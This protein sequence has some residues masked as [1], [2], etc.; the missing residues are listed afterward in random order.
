MPGPALHDEHPRQWRADDLVLLALDRRDDVAELSRA[1]FLECGDEGTLA[2]DGARLELVACLPEELVVDAAQHPTGRGEV[3]PPDQA[4]RFAA[5]GAVE[6]LGHGGAPVDDD[7]LRRRVGHGDASDVEAVAFQASR[8][9]R[10]GFVGSE[11]IDP[12][13]AE[14]LVADLGLGEPL[15][16]LLDHDVAFVPGLEGAAGTGLHLGA[17]GAGLFAS[18]FEAGVGVVDVRLLCFQFGIR[19]HGDTSAVLRF[20]RAPVPADTR[21]FTIVPVATGDGDVARR[22]RGR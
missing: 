7:R 12:A 18:A 1:G 22:G 20:R 21:G 5:R 15:V 8:R 2:D 13:E 19:G 9:R 3:A 11:L 14:R 10:T 4:H 6:R 17:H 16:G